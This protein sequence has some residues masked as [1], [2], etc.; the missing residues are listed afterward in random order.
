LAAWWG[1]LWT[2]IMAKSK[3]E[4][5]GASA[6]KD[7]SINGGNMGGQHRRGKT[8]MDGLRASSAIASKASKRH[9]RAGGHQPGAA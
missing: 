8:G 3:D 1:A 5:S 9:R 7:S 2:K 6:R 4:A